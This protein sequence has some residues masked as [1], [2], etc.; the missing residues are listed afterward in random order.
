M[1]CRRDGLHDEAFTLVDAHSLKP[2]CG[3]AYREVLNAADIVFGDGTGV[4][5]A[6]RLRGIR[7]R[8]NVNGT[9][10]VPA[11]FSATSRFRLPLLPA[12]HRSGLDRRA[13]D[14]AATAFP[15]WT[16][17]GYHHG[18]LTTPDLNAQAIDSINRARPDLLLVGMGNPLQ[19]RW[20]AAHRAQLSVPVCLGVGGLFQYW[21]GTLRR[22]PRRLAAAALSGWGSW[23]AAEEGSPLFA[24]QPAVPDA[25]PPRALSMR[26]RNS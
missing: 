5:W 26:R 22:A 14:H 25:N 3:R 1:L 2:P 6:A 9:D 20:I 21:A 23:P 12:R 17:A 10:L 13:A 8:D 18:Y 19:E 16:L 11:L 15:G 7:L 4:R 24:R